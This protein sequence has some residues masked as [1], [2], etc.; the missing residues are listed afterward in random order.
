[1]PDLKDGESAQV[2]GLARAPYILKKCGRSLFLLLSCV[3]EPIASHR[4]PHLQTP[5]AY[6]R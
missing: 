1:M 2:Q 4:T 3:E 6:A 5:A